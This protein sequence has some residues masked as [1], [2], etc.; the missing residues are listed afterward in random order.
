MQGFVFKLAE[1]L[2]V[3]GIKEEKAHNVNQQHG[4]KQP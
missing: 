3:G 4:E 1:F 2:P